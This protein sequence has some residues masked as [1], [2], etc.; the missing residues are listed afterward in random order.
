MSYGNSSRVPVPA[1]L[2]VTSWRVAWALRGAGPGAGLALLRRMPQQAI[3]ALE[4]DHAGRR[5]VSVMIDPD[6]DVRVTRFPGGFYFAWVTRM[7]LD[8]SVS[9]EKDWG[10]FRL[11]L[12]EMI[13]GVEAYFFGDD[14]RCSS[15]GTRQQDAAGCQDTIG[16]QA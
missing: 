16:G 2:H 14:P 8:F 5:K 9:S 15:I 6:N 12:V 11:G 3:D 10:A 7:Y 13:N 4:P 1:P